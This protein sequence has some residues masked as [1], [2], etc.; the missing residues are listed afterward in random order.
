M[1]TPS[2][3]EHGLDFLRAFAFSLLILYH[4]GMPFTGWDFHI[5]NAETSEGLRNAMFFLN[6][7][8]LPLL[9]FISGAGVAFALRTR[10][11]GAFLAE[12]TRRLLLPLAFGMLVIVP[13]QIYWERLFRNQYQGGFFAWYPHVFRGVPYPKGDLSW[14]H[15]WFVAYLFVYCVALLPLLRWWRS[16]EA[17]RKA[18]A[19]LLTL[20][21]GMLLLAVPSFIIGMTLG[22]RWP[23]THDLISDWANLTGSAYTFF[24]GFTFGC[25]PRL[26]A[27]AT[28]FS[29]FFLAAG[30]FTFIALRFA[31]LGLG[32]ALREAISC[33]NC[34]FW[35]VGLA[36]WSRTVFTRRPAWLDY[37]TEAVYP[38]YI[39]HQT[40]V[41][42][43]MFAIVHQPW[44]W[45]TKFMITTVGTFAGCYLLYE[46]LI[47]RA[48]FLRPLFGLKRAA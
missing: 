22:P 15:L 34:L 46:F 14:H 38:F 27:A 32:A 25:D 28:R 16:S 17:I 10:S 24:V 2:T 5:M 33:L 6:R 42:G 31:D 20:P 4:S 47:R 18:W 19:R 11:S 12:R 13:P 26:L 40:I 9:F 43:I 7:W 39:L 23:V 29:K 37:A 45:W 1:P 21:G 8:R 48:W 3:R 30:V 41:I 36:G 35:V 44:P